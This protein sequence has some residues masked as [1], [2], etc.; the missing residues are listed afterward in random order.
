M[1]CLALHM[2]EQHSAMGSFPLALSG[3]LSTCGVLLGVRAERAQRGEKR[4]M[5]GM[6]LADVGRPSTLTLYPKLWTLT[7]EALDPNAKP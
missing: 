2:A 5:I 1:Q 3:L 7:L 4:E 6:D